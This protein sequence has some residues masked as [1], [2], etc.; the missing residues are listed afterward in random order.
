MEEKIIDTEAQRIVIDVVVDGLRCAAAAL[1]EKI[2]EL[3]NFGNEKS[4][5]ELISLCKF[6]ID[7][8]AKIEVLL[9]LPLR[10]QYEAFEKSAGIPSPGDLL[11]NHDRR[12][13]SLAAAM[14][15]GL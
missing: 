15:Q 8:L 10:D 11:L 4:A 6:R 5:D 3:Q 1:F 13:Q 12:N 7:T 14:L 9:M 2:S